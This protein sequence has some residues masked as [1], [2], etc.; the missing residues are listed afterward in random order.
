MDS[1]PGLCSRQMAASLS[2]GRK[3]TADDPGRFVRRRM[4]RSPTSSGL[5]MRARCIAPTG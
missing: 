1:M 5:S 3:K 2:A 4:A